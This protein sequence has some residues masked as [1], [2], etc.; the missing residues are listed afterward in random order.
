[1]DDQTID[2]PSDDAPVGFTWQRRIALVVVLAI[3]GFWVWAFSPWAPDEKADGIVDQSF[4]REA[5]AACKT[6]QDAL[7]S[8]PPATESTS[9]AA[10]SDVVERSAAPI[11]TMIA[12]LRAASVGLTGK[13]A[14]LAALWINDW[15]TYSVDR[16]AYAKALRNDERAVF[17]VSQRNNEGQITRTMDGFARVNDLKYCIVPIDV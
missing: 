11:A 8:L 12:E 3:A 9:A 17:I 16:Q 15:E 14:E 7:D 10:R 6:M 2:S 1:V 5:N 4:L 13:D